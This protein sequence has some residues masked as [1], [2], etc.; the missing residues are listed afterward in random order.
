MKASSAHRLLPFKRFGE[1]AT[2]DLEVEVS[3]QCGRSVVI[4]GMAPAFRNRRIM[5]AIPLHRYTGNV[6]G[7]PGSVEI[8]P[9]VLLPVGGESHH[10]RTTQIFDHCIRRRN[11]FLRKWSL[12]FRLF[13]LRPCPSQLLMASPCNGISQGCAAPISHTASPLTRVNAVTFLFV[14]FRS[15]LH[16]YK[17]D[18]L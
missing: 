11:E 2:F 3:C 5:G 13:D 17:R 1:A 10:L 16:F 6:C 15:N 18:P 4:D 14:D 9:S 8:E 12:S 7:S